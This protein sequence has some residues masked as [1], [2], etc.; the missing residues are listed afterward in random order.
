[1]MATI[2]GTVLKVYEAVQR[3]GKTVAR[4]DLYDG[5]ELIKVNRIPSVGAFAVGQAV[6]LR[7]KV[8]SN[9][10]GLA[11]LYFSA[12]EDQPPST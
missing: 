12:V 8:Y 3:D 11:V 4:L 2:Q 7:V 10:Y 9:Q 6:T 5:E 1:M